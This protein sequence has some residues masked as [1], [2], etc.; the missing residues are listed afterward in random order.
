MDRSL[1][2]QIDGAARP[3]WLEHLATLNQGAALE[4]VAE[5]VETREQLD[6]L[7]AAGVTRVQGFYF[8]RP[9]PA[10]ELVAYHAAQG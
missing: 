2:A 4:V 5:G 10:A 1:V 9:L 7:L 3:P 8:S 6:T